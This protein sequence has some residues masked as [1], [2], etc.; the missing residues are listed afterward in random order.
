M[1]R[2][3]HITSPLEVE[4]TTDTYRPAA[5][6]KDG[7]IHCSYSYQLRDVANRRF[8]GRDGL[9]IL[10][11]DRTRVPGPVVDEA[12]AGRTEL[13]PH[14]YGHLPMTAVVAVHEFPCGAGG[15]FEL[16]ETMAR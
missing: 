5:F 4:R 6:D 13:F 9:V 1:E 8:A 10:E 7:F 15:L 16:P 12:L 2:I 11:I 14:I 3:F